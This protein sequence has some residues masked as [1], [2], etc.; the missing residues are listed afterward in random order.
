LISTPCYA[1]QKLQYFL[2]SGV[3]SYHFKFDK[4][5]NTIKEFY[6]GFDMSQAKLKIVSTVHN[7]TS[8]SKNSIKWEVERNDQNIAYS[9]NTDSLIL[10]FNNNE[11]TDMYCYFLENEDEFSKSLLEEKKFEVDKLKIY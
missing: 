4:N 3:T 7:V 1:E 9:F 11:S 6:V 8:I 10:S 2:C 5:N